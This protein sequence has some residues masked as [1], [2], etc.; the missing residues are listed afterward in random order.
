[1]LITI[2][3]KNKL[4]TF[5]LPENVSGIHWITD[6][7]NGKKINLLSI[8]AKDGH[9]QLISN[10]DA[11][12]IDQNGVMIPYVELKLYS[13]VLIRDNFSNQTYYIYTSPIY[14]TTYRELSINNQSKINCGYDS[15][16]NISYKLEGIPKKAFIIEKENNYYYLTILQNTPI[17]INQ[18]LV[19]QTKRLE[20]GDVIFMYGL[21]IILMRRD[22]VDYLLVNNPANLLEFTATYVNVVSNQNEFVDNNEELTDDSFFKQ[23]DYFYRTPHFYKVLNNYVL[24]IDSPPQKKEDDNTP[25]TLTIGPMVTM[26]M[27]SVVMLLSTLSQVNKGEKDMASSMTTLLMSGG[28]LASSLLWPLLTRG[29]QKLSN[30]MYEIKRQKLYKRY[31]N[32]KEKDIQMELENQR[33]S[34]IENNLSVTDCQN[35]IKNKDI[36]LWQRRLKDEDFLTLPVG[37]GNLP[38]QIEIKYPEKHFSLNSDNLLDI[39]YTLGEKERILN[40]VPITFSFKDN[41][42]TGIVGNSILTKE[43]VDRIILQIMANYSYD[44]VKLVTF[45]STDNEKDWEYMKTLPHSWSN[46]KMFR[47]FGSSND[48][49]REIIYGLE[50]IYSERKNSERENQIYTPYY[51]IVTDAIKSI[52][53]YDFIKNVMANQSNVGFSIIMLVD[54]ITALPNECKNF[55]QVDK[56]ECSIF[57]SVINSQDQKFKIDFS[58]IE[59]IYN[60]SKILANIPID[61]KSNA[62]SKLPDVYHFLEMYQ[63]GKVD[64]LNCYERW[65]RS[66]P[67]LSLSSPVGIGKNGEIITLDLHEKYHGPHGLIAGTTGSGK[68]EFIISYIL[69]LAI[70]YHP[71]E[72]QIILI[73]YKGGSLTSAF[74]N[75]MYYLPHLAGTIT[76]LD[77][78]ELNRS[79]AS[80]EA[81]VKRRQREFNDAKTISNESTMD[82]YKYQK[83]YREGRLKDKE[84]IAHLFIISDEFAELKEQ[85]PEFMDNL[86]SV[87]RVGRSLG[88]HL[89][90]ATQKPGGVVN[91]QIWSNTRFR[92]CLKVQDTSDS[93][94]VI[95]KPDAAY[96]Q[97][98]GRFYLQVGTD[99]VFTLGQSSWSGGQYYPNTTFKKDLDISVNEINNIG[100][101]TTT[102]EAEVTEVIESQGEELTN[103]V[104]YICD[105]AKE[106]QIKIRKLWLDKIPNKIF[107]D[108]LKNKYNLGKEDYIINPIVGEYD[109]PDTQNQYALTVPFTKLGNALIYGI[110]GS[111]KEDFITS[112]IYSSMITYTPD[113]I[114]FYILDFGAETLRKFNNSPYVGDIMYINDYD[115]IVN[116][117]KMINEEI[118]KRKKIFANFGGTY[119][120]YIKS[121]NEKFANWIIVVNNF[122]NLTETYED[123]SEDITKISRDAYKYGIYL[124]VTA[125]RENAIRVKLRQNFSLV[126]VLQLNDD[127]EYSS[128]LGNVKG[129]LPAKNKGRGLFKK[130]R[131]F[132]FQTAIV[133]DE[134]Q[135]DYILNYC[136]ECLEKYNYKAKRVPILPDEVD[137]NYL[138]DLLTNKKD[139]IVG[140]NKNNLEPINYPFTKNTIN[141]ILSNDLENCYEFVNSLI[142]EIIYQNY[143]EVVMLNTTESVFN[144]KMSN[145]I[146]SDKFNEIIN[147]YNDYMNKLNCI[148]EDNGKNIKALDNVKK[149][150]IVIY[151][152]KDFISKLDETSLSNF[153]NIIKLNDTLKNVFFIFVDSPES[154]KLYA[155]EDWYRQAVDQTKGIWI[156]NGFIQQSLIKISKLSREDG[157]EIDNSFGFVILNSKQFKTKFI[158]KFDSENVN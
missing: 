122:E 32:T 91:Q 13:F 121:S 101:V 92:V 26:A 133:A 124:L 74:A 28:M 111:G 150:I 45:T 65:K 117:I 144:N 72:V 132:E 106:K 85:Q 71:D 78:N 27:S 76:N 84:P 68:S 19:L 87:A 16:C 43:L 50:K 113:E 61:I 153:K 57:S 158:S 42:A 97:K 134:N 37:I 5:S 56:D 146:Y 135:N 14:D 47:F 136:K 54:K 108:N 21:K 155:Y 100:F 41:I 118:E 147:N 60:C 48:D 125:T 7:E 11:F 66:N 128:I 86:I 130:D 70:N 24:S 88:V 31:I 140:V 22:G 30:K 143:Y 39:A 63:V 115:K 3:K 141:L 127:S 49:Y 82:I 79:L 156:G 94:E 51:V 110:S 69:S 46:D 81:E 20:Y 73:D 58:P 126:Y 77:G 25:A 34:L 112:V 10:H 6:F 83:L 89:I 1:M 15:S 55:I 152:V 18:K 2:I 157:E 149:Q 64:Q 120:D 29:Y 52:E 139:I 137:F 145:K 33:K 107:V 148:Y 35:I 62:E 80:I 8:E 53:S 114:N 4:N 17:Y 138:K 36:K 23:V 116:L 12:A 103:I 96:L 95:K 105:I 44:E 104:K 40:D 93:Q 90:L 9:W 151:G 59:D 109:D 131:I 123:I 98:Q 129:K 154:I 102:K 67:I 142:K 38:M 99:E 119:Q 75:D